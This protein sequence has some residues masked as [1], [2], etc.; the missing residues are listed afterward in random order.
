MTILNDIALAQYTTLGLGGTARHFAHCASLVDIREA[1]HFAAAQSL[2]VFVLGGGSNVIVAD[3]GFDGLVIHIALRGISTATTPDGVQVTAAAGEPWD[4]FVE[5]CV[6][7]AYTGVE[8]LSG[9]PGLVGAT[10]IQNVGAYGQEVRDTITAVEVLDRHSGAVTTLANRDCA[11]GYRQSRFKGTDADRFVVTAVTFLLQPNAP[12]VMRYPELQK[13]VAASGVGQPTLANVR[14]GVLALRRGKSMVLDPDDP[15]SRSVGS[16]FTNPIITPNEL[17]RVRRRWQQTGSTDIVPSF[18]SGDLMKIPA[19][20]LVEHAGFPKGYRLG[21]VGV[22]AH[23]SLAL[24]N[25]G[26]TTLQLLNLAH[27]IQNAV[28]ERFGI[29]L[30]REPVV[31]SFR[32]ANRPMYN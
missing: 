16:F 4:P 13:A 11:F 23:H 14:D 8:C 32:P 18:P 2:K 30:E 17:E 28:R 3:E 12:P 19:A 26:G 15:H 9:I 20:W 25:Y 22:S 31:V 10:P 6:R 5:Y 21:N 27:R 24:V 1:F 29:T 7:H